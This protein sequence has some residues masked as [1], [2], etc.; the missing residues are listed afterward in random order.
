MYGTT[1]LKER[2][3][4]IINFLI[5]IQGKNMYCTKCGAKI[6]DEAVFCPRC[7]Y[8]TR[9][10]GVEE[11]GIS[12]RI[13]EKQK[14]IQKKTEL[15]ID[16]NELGI[17][18]ND[19]IDTI[20]EKS[21]RSND[22]M[23]RNLMILTGILGIVAVFIII[24]LIWALVENREKQDSENTINLE[25]TGEKNIA[26]EG[27]PQEDIQKMLEE[28]KQLILSGDITGAQEK[29]EAI[30]EIDSQCEDGYLLGADICLTQGDYNRALVIL[31]E[32][33]DKTQSAYLKAREE[34]ICKNIVISGIQAEGSGS[35][36]SYTYDSL[37]NLVKK[38]KFDEWYNLTGWDEF[39][40]NSAGNKIRC[41]TYDSD[42]NLTVSNSFG[43]DEQGYLVSQVDYDEAGT[44][45]GQHRYIYDGEGH[46]IECDDYNEQGEII[47]STKSEYDSQG[48]KI[49]DLGYNAKGNLMGWV[50]TVYNSKGEI[51]RMIR[52]D[53]DGYVLECND[54]EYNAEGNVSKVYS[55]SGDEL[56]YWAET[57]YDEDGNKQRTVKYRSEEQGYY[58]CE[59][60]KIGKKVKEYNEDIGIA[61][62]YIYQY[63][64]DIL[65]RSDMKP[66]SGQLS[67]SRMTGYRRIPDEGA[68]FAGTAEKG[69]TYSVI[70]ESD[71]FYQ[72]E[73]G[74]YFSKYQQDIQ[75]VAGE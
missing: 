50:E 14:S 8:K 64:G 1:I 15:L 46:Q 48:R 70:G 69:A 4:M 17:Y 9:K 32:G 7:G 5:I 71:K 33:Y 56:N 73:Q 45:I 13:K 12:G 6:S 22:R 63:I 21:G 24:I 66:L 75:F 42:G 59:Y 40:Y 67:V 47:W 28:G 72:V 25:E 34:Y 18:E 36:F 61:Y 39:E 49:K 31:E 43:Y 62:I 23:K 37:G 20:E 3:R 57:E 55:Y 11:P 19:I 26:E 2:E 29:Y 51:S 53:E 74:W 10:R 35:G 58:W 60:D 52:Y 27:M 41:N 38:D 16:E 44:A 54:T 30:K 68:A 65:C